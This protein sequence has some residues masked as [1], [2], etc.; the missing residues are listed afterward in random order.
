MKITNLYRRVMDL[1]DHLSGT[2]RSY[3]PQK[4]IELTLV[5]AQ[6]FKYF[7]SYDSFFS[8]T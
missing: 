1:E 3:S 5:W 4:K 6:F 7:V 8:I 2:H